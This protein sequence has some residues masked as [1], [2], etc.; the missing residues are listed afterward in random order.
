MI[1]ELGVY[2]LGD[3]DQRSY[4]WDRSAWDAA[5]T[6]PSEPCAFRKW[7]SMRRTALRSKKFEEQQ[8]AKPGQSAGRWPKDPGNFDWFKQVCVVA[9]LNHASVT[10]WIRRRKLGEVAKNL[11]KSVACT[12]V[13]G[14]THCT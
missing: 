5:V 4:S 10:L 6:A 9:D 12:Q 13:V 2:Q 3:T 11:V 1:D 14:F 7:V 8:K